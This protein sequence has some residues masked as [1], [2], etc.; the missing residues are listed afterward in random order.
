MN[1]IIE[2]SD[3]KVIVTS[4]YD[5]EYIEIKTRRNKEIPIDI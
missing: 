4:N 3:P 2:C 1:P 5:E